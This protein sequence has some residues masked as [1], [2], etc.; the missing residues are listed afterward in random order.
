M[1]ERFALISSWSKLLH[2]P[3]VNI[4]LKIFSL[5][6]LPAI[7][8][9]ILYCNVNPKY[10][11]FLV[12]SSGLLVL[13]IVYNDLKEKRFLAFW[14]F[15]YAMLFFM[16]NLN[17]GFDMTDEPYNLALSYFLPKSYF[18]VAVNPFS[19]KLMNLLLVIFPK[20][21]FL[22]ERFVAAL[23]MAL[24]IYF[25]VK[26]ILL[27]KKA[28]EIDLVIFFFVFMSAVG[29]SF[30]YLRFSRPYDVVP[31]LIFATLIYV[32]LAYIQKSN[33]NLYSLLFGA[34]LVLSVYTR[35]SAFVFDFLLLLIFLL[36]KYKL[37]YLKFSHLLYLSIGIFAGLA[38]IYFLKID[39]TLPV[40]KYKNFVY[41]FCMPI[42]W[43]H[44]YSYLFNLYKTEFIEILKFFA[45][46]FLAL[47]A[48]YLLTNKLRYYRHFEALVRIVTVLA[49][50]ISFTY[51]KYHG[52]SKLWFYSWFYLGLALFGAIYFM[53]SLFNKKLD[54]LN[55]SVLALILIL[56]FAGS[57]VG[58]RKIA[59]NGA[60]AFALIFGLLMWDVKKLDP[61][62]TVTVLVL[63][64]SL[65]MSY[66]VKHFYRDYSN[67]NKL[68]STF[69]TDELKGIMTKKT[70]VWD[71]ESFYNKIKKYDLSGNYITANK[72][73]LFSLLMR[74]K[75]MKLCW[76]YDPDK[77]LKS[78]K[79][80]REPEYVIFSNR[81][82][83]YYD[84]DRRKVLAIKRD[85]SVIQRT[86]KILDS[87]YQPVLHSRDNIF[88]LYKLK[89]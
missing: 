51:F 34:V 78:I 36:A 81:S 84:W 83:R 46:S 11:N 5:L 63:I 20:P 88:V 8:L 19:Y 39:L 59:F 3:S 23:F 58:F 7:T 33:D 60:L 12:V 62:I 9:C 26:S 30:L 74:Q 31:V 13:P 16:Y 15:F 25:A 38:G 68:N 52:L 89:K 27:F 28:D 49:A 80:R 24:I 53:L 21:S 71:V 85:I 10:F 22:W 45:L 56:S 65:G 87:L 70:K 73:I 48:L 67:K 41:N 42:T 37:S 40:I 18:D 29:Y 17:Y 50:L 44:G 76:F 82:M 86:K 4:L 64:F 2:K 69:E 54:W 79:D 32:G 14:A 1:Q 6:L 55:L 43:S 47:L 57:D 35:I 77:I 75:P 66:R 61:F 72:T